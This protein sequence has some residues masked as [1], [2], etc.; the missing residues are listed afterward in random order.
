MLMS[1]SRVSI[2]IPAYN[3]AQRLPAFLDSVLS[4]QHENPNEIHE[5][6]VV[7][8]GSSDTTAEIVQERERANQ[9]LKLIRLP[10]NQGKGGAVAAGVATAI[11]DMIVFIDA[12]GATPINELP[13]MI[14]VLGEA[15]IGVGNRWM[16]GAHVQKSTLLRHFAGWVYMTYMSIF[17]LSGID[18]MCGFKGYQSHVAKDLFNNLIEKRW[19]FDTEVAYKAVRKKYVITNFP[20][21][22]ES[23]D[24]SKL[25]SFTLIKSA[26]QIFPL[27]MKIR[28]ADAGK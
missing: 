14:N 13:K 9:A 3:E 24:G 19:L 27:I 12:D 20:I 5:I 11:G 4:Y 8:D 26:F 10:Q 23:K 6:L 1:S 22:W 25:D 18:T 7:D 28:K 15:D 21:E 2:I 16:N 17:G